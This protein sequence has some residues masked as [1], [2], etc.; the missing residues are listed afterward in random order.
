MK[1]SPINDE[2]EPRQWVTPKDGIRRVDKPITR[3]W[4]YVNLVASY[5][6]D[7]NRF[8]PC[9]ALFRGQRKP[10]PLLPSIARKDWVN[11]SP[12]R[13]KN[14]LQELKRL[15]PILLNNAAPTPELHWLSLAQHN[16]MYTR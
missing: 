12:E 8:P 3:L 6:P 7:P 10:E 5:A 1:T 4:H 15:S 11:Y 13:E 2:K 14:A 16:G 9:T